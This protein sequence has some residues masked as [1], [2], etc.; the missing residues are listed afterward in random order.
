MSY[1][2]PEMKGIGRVH[3][4]PFAASYEPKQGDLIIAVLELYSPPPLANRL[5][6]HG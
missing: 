2:T 4:S 5:T 6:Q 3:A 1:S